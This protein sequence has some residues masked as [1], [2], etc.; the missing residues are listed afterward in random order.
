MKAYNK[1][2]SF[3]KQKCLTINPKDEKVKLINFFFIFIAFLTINTGY[4]VGQGMLQNPPSLPRP[5]KGVTFPNNGFLNI[6]VGQETAP[7]TIQEISSVTCHHCSEFHKKVYPHLK[8]KYIDKGIVR[9]VLRH[10]PI[11]GISLKVS[12]ILS[13]IPQKKRLGVIE[14]L[15]KTQPK[16]FPKDLS[17]QSMRMLSHHMA[18]LCQISADQ[19]LKYV[20]D[21]ALLDLV[22]QDRYA[23]D[24]SIEIDGT[25][26]FIIN[27]D[28]LLK[29]T[30]LESFD[31]MISERLKGI[32]HHDG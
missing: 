11:D 26:T 19:A 12:M 2:H 17:L 14:K 18:D 15:W 16:W 13:Q 8:K 25:P 27:G 22:I 20:Q 9:W 30:T 28:V 5:L 4:A 7:I 1:L 31:H 21:E 29:E 3:T 32:S 10:C 6:S 24:Q 23:L